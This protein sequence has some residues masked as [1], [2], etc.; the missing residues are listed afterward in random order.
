VIASELA[1]V[2][3]DNQTGEAGSVLAIEGKATVSLGKFAPPQG[4]KT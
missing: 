4:S 1:A 2:S 3:G